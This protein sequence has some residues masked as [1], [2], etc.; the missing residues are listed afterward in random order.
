M[1]QSHQASASTTADL[2]QIYE[3][4]FFGKICNRRGV[5]RHSVLFND[6][7]RAQTSTRQVGVE[8]V[9]WSSFRR[10]MT[11]ELLAAQCSGFSPVPSMREPGHSRCTI[12]RPEDSS[13]RHGEFARREARRGKGG[14]DLSGQSVCKAYARLLAVRCGWS[15]S[16]TGCVP[17]TFKGERGEQPIRFV[18]AWLF[19]Q[20]LP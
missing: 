7:T 11:L 12:E 9:W 6:V 17:N 16:K 3:S 5:I 8:V 2:R 19:L 14:F 20:R 13:L 4:E 1:P 18:G 15:R 10:V